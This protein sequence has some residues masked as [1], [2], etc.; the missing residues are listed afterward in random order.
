M[1]W[2]ILSVAGIFEVVWA[3][4]MK[5][6]DGFTRMGFAALSLAA[7][8][9]SVGLLAWALRSL[10]VGTGYAVWTGI[11]AAGTA[12]MGI[13]IFGEPANLPRLFF[14]ALILAGILGLKLSTPAG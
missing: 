10:P 6:S 14:L 7:M 8:A 5:A 2:L 9:V 12:V 1:P 13:L 4:A 3:L 11:G